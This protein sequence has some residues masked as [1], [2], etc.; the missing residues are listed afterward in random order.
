MQRPLP[1]RKE[2]KADHFCNSILITCKK[3]TNFCVGF[4]KLFIKIRD[5]PI[6]HKTFN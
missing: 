3:S 4:I 5:S 1:L 2:S 6:R